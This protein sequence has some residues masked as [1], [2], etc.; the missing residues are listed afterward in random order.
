D[1]AFCSLYHIYYTGGNY[2][3]SD[4]TPIVTS[5]PL[6]S[7]DLTRVWDGSSLR[8]WNWDLAMGAD[9]NPVVVFAVLVTNSDHRYYYGRWNGSAWVTTQIAAAG[10]FLV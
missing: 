2:F 10:S 5:L 7:S 9:G 8:G 6:G 3:K 4:G 1:T